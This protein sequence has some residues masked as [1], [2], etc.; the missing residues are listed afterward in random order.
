MISTDGGKSRQGPH[1][2][3]ICDHDLELEHPPPSDLHDGIW[4]GQELVDCYSRWEVED[5]MN[6]PD[7]L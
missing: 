1:H 6:R 5:R 4:W 2:Y 3:R 7:E